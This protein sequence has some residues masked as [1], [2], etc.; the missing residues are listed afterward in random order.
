MKSTLRSK[1]VS[2]GRFSTPPQQIPLH[3]TSTS[4]PNHKEMYPQF[5]LGA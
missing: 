2:T 3:I 5:S 1:W 4:Q